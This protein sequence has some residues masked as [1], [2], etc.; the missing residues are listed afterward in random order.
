M[1]ALTSGLQCVQPVERT[2]L[3]TIILAFGLVAIESLA[4]ATASTN[5]PMVAQWSPGK[6][7]PSQRPQPQ[8]SLQVF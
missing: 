8:S 4:A 5:V 6:E 7:K 1:R 2:S 3:S